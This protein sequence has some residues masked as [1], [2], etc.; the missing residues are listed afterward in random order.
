MIIFLLFSIVP[1]E[2]VIKEKCEICEFNHFC[3]DHGKLIFDQVI[4]YDEN[5]SVIAWRLMKDNGPSTEEYIWRDGL[6]IRHVKYK[7]LKE[8]W[9]QD[10]PELTERDKLPKE[11]RRELS[12]G[13][14][15]KQRNLAPDR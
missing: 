15:K 11:R 2:I 1:I 8:T 5:S 10:D 7:I 12:N 14:G 9:T 6:H 13:L 3:D 4:F